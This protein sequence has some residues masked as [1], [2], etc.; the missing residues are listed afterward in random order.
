V[1]YCLRA[2]E[3]DDFVCGICIKGFLLLSAPQSKM[4]CFDMFHPAKPHKLTERVVITAI[5]F[6]AN[7]LFK[8]SNTKT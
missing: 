7:D 1:R 3:M 4:I 8:F 5:G 6:H 2:T